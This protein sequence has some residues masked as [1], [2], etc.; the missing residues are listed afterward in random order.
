MAVEAMA[1]PL[2]K[3]KKIR[4][5]DEIRTRGGQAISVYR[6][7]RRRSQVPTAIGNSSS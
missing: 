5:W 7:Q 1:K 2:E 4:S 3:L 6:E